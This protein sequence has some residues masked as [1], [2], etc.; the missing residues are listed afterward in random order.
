[1]ITDSQSGTNVHEVA[2]GIYRINTP[3]DIPGGRRF[4]F[5]SP[6]AGAARRR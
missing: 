2:A 1:M 6:R 5:F 3:V 4:N